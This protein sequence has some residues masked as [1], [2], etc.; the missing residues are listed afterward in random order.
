MIKVSK[1]VFAFILT[2]M[3]TFSVLVVGVSAKESGTCGENLT[4]TFDES[5][6]VLT[7]FGYGEMDNYDNSSSVSI[8]PWYDFSVKSVILP[9]GLVNI[10]NFA[11]L[12]CLELTEITIPDSVTSIGEGAFFNC[13]S[14][15]SIAISASVTNIGYAA[16]LR[17]GS[18][19][20]ITVDSKN[21]YYSSDSNGVLFDKNKTMLIQYPAGNTRTNY[22][23][24]N[25]VTTICDGAFASCNNL[26]S[27]TIPRGITSIGDGVFYFCNSLTSIT[28]PEGVISIGDSAF[29]YCKN[30]TRITI[31]NSVISIETWAF[32]GCSN[33]TDVYYFGSEDEW[34]KIAIDIS[35]DAL[36]TAIIH[37]N[38]VPES[39]ETPLKYYTIIWIVDGDTVNMQEVE[40]GATIT[41]VPANPNKEGYG[42]I[43]W[44]DSEGNYPTFPMTMPAKNLTFTAVFEE[45]GDS[46]ETDN[47]TETDRYETIEGVLEEYETTVII[48]GNDYWI[49][50]IRINGNWYFLY[51]DY[52][53]Q[54]KIESY[55]NRQVVVVVCDGYVLD[56]VLFSDLKTS[57]RISGFDSSISTME[58]YDGVFRK[59]DG[60]RA[61]KWHTASGTIINSLANTSIDI[62]KLS[63]LE[64]LRYKNVSVTIKSSDK[65]VVSLDNGAW[66]AESDSMTIELGDIDV[67]ESFNFSEEVLKFKTGWDFPEEQREH[68]VTLYY[69][70]T[71][72]VNG[73][74]ITLE[75]SETVRLVNKDYRTGGS[76]ASTSYEKQSIRELFEE[77][78]KEASKCSV[79]NSTQRALIDSIIFSH[80]AAMEV[81]DFKNTLDAAEKVY[82]LSCYVSG[83][84]GVTYATAGEY[85]I[86]AIYEQA[87]QGDNELKKALSEL[88]SDLRNCEE[89]NIFVQW[90]YA[91][92]QMNK[93]SNKRVG[94]HCPVD[95]YVYDKT[96]K[97]V[98]SIVRDEVTQSDENIHAFVC[99]DDKT[100]Y[101]PTDTDY[102]IK[103]VA[104]G[105]GT[106][107]YIITE[108]YSEEKTRKTYYSNIPL[109][110]ND[111]YTGV[112]V[113]SV[114][115]DAD[116]YNLV[117]SNDTLFEYDEITYEKDV[118]NIQVDIRTPSTTTISYGDSIVLHADVTE[119]LP[120]GWRIEWSADNG[121]FRYSTSADGTTCTITPNKSGDT[122]F[123]VK[124][125]DAQNNEISSDTQK[126][127]SKAGFFDKI[128]AFFKKLFGLTKIITQS[129]YTN[130]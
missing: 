110:V 118:D 104:T 1:R 130:K 19:A 89:F 68:S 30:L 6:G 49:S 27:I 65:D 26:A 17:C 22:I 120:E 41:T 33:L 81:V 119:A 86:D 14:L 76:Y 107:D 112:I 95:V 111:Y 79:L 5:T 4:W 122:T 9:D 8:S 93:N 102:D 2:L 73:E 62:S 45:N 47:P 96:D 60:S 124:V 40:Y 88:L 48:N 80:L 31:P 71:G 75:A 55:K 38:Y 63:S 36:T 7:I 113:S 70:V 18:L 117:S 61:D 84:N 52:F 83:I 69:T 123:T 42:F 64:F 74:T 98:L 51:K 34:N 94:V 82:E 103:I 25:N 3:M 114:L 29:F 58:Y 67:G 85:V 66:D 43:G 59:Y 37:F 116:L 115:P 105:N 10:G 13:G 87:Y 56:I 57:P 72:T 77:M 54:C 129:I 20:N 11:F 101:L 15:M 44:V 50:E 21:S 100:I 106:M 127:T 23:I 78:Q 53:Y 39:G 108:Y 24:P 99:E 97:I 126:M 91:Q 28:I 90:Y 12:G 46:E 121:N 32:R 128:I 35:N 16:F 109:V 125:F 92:Q